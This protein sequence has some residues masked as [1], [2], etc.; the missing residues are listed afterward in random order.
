MARERGGEER[1]LGRYIDALTAAFGSVPDRARAHAKAVPVLAEM[2][3]DPRV[4]EDILRGHLLGPAALS[5]GHYP[6]IGIDV[7]RNQH[8]HLVANCWITLPDGSTDMSTKAIHHHGDM[9]LTTVTAFG[10]GYEHWL[11]TPPSVVDP[12]RDLYRMSLVERSQHGLGDVS[13]VGSGFAHLPMYPATT[14]VTYALW[15]PRA[16]PTWLD[17]VKSV[18]FLRRRNASLRRAALRMGLRRQLQL[19]VVEY[20]D[21]HPSEE[22][23]IGMRRREEFPRGPVEDYLHSLFHVL[24]ATG[25]ER[26]V[27]VVRNRLES[28]S[29]ADP[30]H[31]ALIEQLVHELDRGHPI[32]ARLSEGHVGVRFANFDRRQIEAALGAHRI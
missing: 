11:F 9:L 14:S 8:F 25:L 32:A 1:P 21:F 2:A 29:V 20:F 27:P 12:G 13:F 23:F 30:A 16:A 31:A 19:K 5:S 4:L 3:A 24:Q 6:V 10:S 17:Q 26:L 15:S 7:E 28:G 22:G 18:P